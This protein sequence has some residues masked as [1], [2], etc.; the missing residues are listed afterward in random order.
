M[1]DKMISFIGGGNMATAIIGGLLSSGLSDCDHIYATAAHEA[2]VLRLKES[3]GIDAGTDNKIAAQKADILFLAVKPNLFHK[4]IP[5][6]RHAITDD[7][8]IVSIAAGQPMERIEDM[9]ERSIK[10]VRV[11]PPRH[12]LVLP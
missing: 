3:F 10:L 12:W 6:I 11:M 1:I 8:I 2:T 4:V 9:F 7:T 5:E